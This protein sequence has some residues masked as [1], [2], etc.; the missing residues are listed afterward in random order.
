LI[1]A[2]AGSSKRKKTDEKDTEMM[3]RMMEKRCPV[4]NVAKLAGLKWAGV[5]K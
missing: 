5:E 4:S 1:R 2:E 3:Q